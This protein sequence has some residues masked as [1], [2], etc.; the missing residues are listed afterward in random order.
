MSYPDLPSLNDEQLEHYERGELIGAA[1]AAFEERLLTDPTLNRQLR[2]YRETIDSLRLVGDRHDLRTK[3]RAFQAQLDHDVA[4]DASAQIVAPPTV[5]ATQLPVAAT[6]LPRPTMTIDRMP[7]VTAPPTVEGAPAAVPFTLDRSVLRAS[8]VNPLKQVWRAHRLTMGVAASVAILTAFS[9]L[10]LTAAWKRSQQQSAYGFALLRREVD[11]LKRTQTAIIRDINATTPGTTIEQPDADGG[12]AASF[13]GTGFALS[14][15]GYL[16]TSYHVVKDADSLLVE[17]GALHRRFRAVTVYRDEAHDLAILRITD[18]RFSTLGKLPYTFK[19]AD[20]DLGERVYTLGYPREDV[21]YGE[22]ALA[23][24][25]GFEG[26]S[27][28]YQVSVP[29]NPG[30]SGGPLLDDRGNLIGIISGR[31]LDIQSAA[32]A[33][34]ST[35]LLKLLDNLPADDTATA[36]PVLPRANQLAGNRRPEQLRRLQDFV[37]VVKVYN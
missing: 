12:R 4:E 30:N 3:F 24:R 36:K 5:L 14:A 29:V 26:D 35:T 19:K 20:A 1:R 33:V 37:F 15:N 21:V 9:T 8:W 28:F 22:G 25:T 11:K 13:S 18:R 31:Q 2:R 27:A 32:F 7:A 17:G 10:W 6:E 34:K 23:A 16:V